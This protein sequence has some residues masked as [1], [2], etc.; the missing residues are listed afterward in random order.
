MGLG[1][2]DASTEETIEAPSLPLMQLRF[3]TDGGKQPFAEGSAAPPVTAS[4]LAWC[5]FSSNVAGTTSETASGSDCRCSEMA[6]ADRGPAAPR[7]AGRQA[8]ACS[9]TSPVLALI[10][11]QGDRV[12]GGVG[13]RSSLPTLNT[14]VISA[15]RRSFACYCFCSPLRRERCERRA[16]VLP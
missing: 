14:G 3:E 5:S 15:C 11:Q 10:C 9:E 4:R 1:V 16:Q 2:D 12:C 6:T 8:P 7:S 13:V